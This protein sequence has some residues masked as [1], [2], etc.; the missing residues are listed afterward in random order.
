MKRF[1]RE[2]FQREKL[3]SQRSPSSSGP[4]QPARRRAAVARHASGPCV[5]A[6]ASQAAK[7]EPR[8][9]P[10]AALAGGHLGEDHLAE[11]VG[12]PGRVAVAEARVPGEVGA[13]APDRPRRCPGQQRQE[14]GRVGPGDALRRRRRRPVEQ[15]PHQPLR[16]V[17]RAVRALHVA[18]VHL[19]QRPLR[20]VLHPLDPLH[21]PGAPGCRRCASAAPGSPC[22]RPWRG[23]VAAL[24]V[25][26]RRRCARRRVPC[27]DFVPCSDSW[28]T[29]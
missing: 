1:K 8:A 20:P 4:P 28:E 15:Q 12:E 10:A 29:T 17:G 21:A 19:V 16:R 5:A 26:G 22:R 23:A 9:G 6:A 18:P 7:L 3:Y 14:A 27:S 13:V 2:T 25:R 24:A 11:P